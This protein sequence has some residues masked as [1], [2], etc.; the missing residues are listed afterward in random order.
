VPTSKCPFLRHA[1]QTDYIELFQT[2]IGSMINFIRVCHS[3][4]LSLKA[5]LP[6]VLYV[7]YRQWGII[8]LL[9]MRAPDI[10]QFGAGDLGLMSHVDMFKNDV[11][12]VKEYL[13]E[14]ATE[15][16]RVTFE[17]I[18]AMKDEIAKRTETVP[19]VASLV[20]NM[21]LFQLSA[22]VGDTKTVHVDEILAVLGPSGTCP[23]RSVGILA[24]AK[25]DALKKRLRTPSVW[26]VLQN[27]FPIFGS[28]GQKMTLPW[29]MK[30]I[31]PLI[32]VAGKTLEKASKSADL[33]DTSTVDGVIQ[34]Q[35]EDS[36]WG[37]RFVRWLAFQPQHLLGPD[38]TVYDGLRWDDLAFVLAFYTNRLYAHMFRWCH[39]RAHRTDTVESR[40]RQLHLWSA[41]DASLPAFSCSVHLLEYYLNNTDILDVLHQV[42]GKDDDEDAFEVHTTFLDTYA[43]KDGVGL[44]G[45]TIRLA[46]DVALERPGNW[47]IV[48]L[49]QGTRTYT[50]EQIPQDVAH[51]VYVGLDAYGT[52]AVHAFHVHYQ[53]SHRRSIVSE[54]ILPRTHPLRRLLLPTE[55]GTTNGVGRAVVSLLNP[56]GVFVNMF[57]FEYTGG[58]D[59]MLAEYRP[60]DPADL[61]DHRTKLVITE[62]LSLHPVLGDYQ[63][64]WTYIERHLTPTVE[65]MVHDDVVV[66]WRAAMDD[67]RHSTVGQLVTQAFFTQVRH[68]FMSNKLSGHIAR[69]GHILSPGP[70]DVASAFYDMMTSLVTQL[71]WVPLTRGFAYAGCHSSLVEFYSGL[72]VLGKSMRHPLGMPNEI[73]V[74]TGM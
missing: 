16:G 65:D 15:N 72:D 55:L 9:L 32:R 11:E 21:L 18:M 54:A 41:E 2:H 27:P 31:A 48:D 74:S 5:G 52:V 36:T 69:Y 53:A 34:K 67:G 63:R 43:K 61:S 66:A 45:A 20:E 60:W 51:R 57:P 28:L 1:A 70:F 24:K 62:D 38:M 12:F 58:L 29:Y 68:N 33:I 30:P 37:D 71:R 7:T 3:L 49:R 4:G 13:T 47:R 59:R 35:Y 40:R 42:R 25:L 64:W 56:T 19:S 10:T 46:P 23:R 44:V 22:D 8:G 14:H 39:N 50:R 6:I 17:T 73:E 26:E